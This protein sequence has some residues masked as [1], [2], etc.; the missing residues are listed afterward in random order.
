[1]N[2]LL[3]AEEAAGA[4]TL[5][6]VLEAGANVVAV[7]ASPV[8]QHG[9]HLSVWNLAR[10]LGCAT[11]SAELVKEQ[12]FAGHVRG[13]G[14]DIIL[15]VHSLFVIQ[16]EVLQAPRLGSFNLH[17]GPLPHYAGLNSVSWAIYR[18]E[19]Q[20]GVTLHR[21][22][23]KIDA[24]PIVYQEVFG[25]GDEETGLS[26]TAKCVNVGVPLVLR[27]LH[28]A[29]RAPSDIPSTPQDLSGR[30][31]FG[32]E[33]PRNGNISWNCPARQIVDFIRAADFFPFRSPWGHP[34]ACLRNSTLCI[35]KAART[36]RAADLPAGSVGKVTGGAVEVA[37]GGE[38]IL[39]RQVVLDGN[40]RPA[41]EVLKTGDLLLDG[42]VAPACG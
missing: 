1:M 11:W 3:I 12:S 37:G 15:N 5:R 9:R 23:P 14:V 17:P 22:A 34:R 27:L 29:A 25:I 10:Q 31:Y 4:R 2:V 26:L 38:W 19:K 33:V 16:E 8:T 35:A 39:V 40:H 24:G 42:E 21:M 30:Q 20:H 28:A 36:R 6:A 13:A 7:M 32:R 41:S 18:G